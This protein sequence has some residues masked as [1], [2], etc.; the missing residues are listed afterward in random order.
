[1]A[2][3]RWR[4]ERDREAKVA[5]GARSGSKSR[6]GDGYH[7]SHVPNIARGARATWRTFRIATWRTCP[8]IKSH[9]ASTEVATGVGWQRHLGVEVAYLPHHLVPRASAEVATPRWRRERQVRHVASAASP[10]RPMWQVLRW[11][12]ERQVRHVASAALPYSPTWQVR[13]WRRRGGDAEVAT[14]EGSGSGGGD[15]EMATQGVGSGAGL[16]NEGG[17]AGRGIGSGIGKR[18]W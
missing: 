12:R 15:A 17:D 8:I 2:T 18:R 14:G 3:P 9:V 4:W 5:T 16:G 6:G 1:M 10:Y 11:R 7:T 13:R